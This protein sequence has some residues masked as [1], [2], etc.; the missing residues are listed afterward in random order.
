MAL[1]KIPIH[2][3]EVFRWDSGELNS[4]L[5]AEKGRTIAIDPA[6]DLTPDILCS[7]GLPAID[8]I[9]ITHVQQEHA[10]GCVNFPGVPVC[11]PEGDEYL[12]NGREAYLNC[13]TKWEAPWDWDGRGN[14]KGHLAGAPNEYPPENP[15]KLA[16]TLKDGDIFPPLRIVSTP[17][18]GK[19]AVSFLL[20]TKEGLC[21]FCGDLI[22]GG[23][24][25]IHSWYECEWDYGQNGG[26]KA[27]KN[28]VTRLMEMDVK[29]LMPSHGEIIFNGRKALKSLSEKLSRIL[30]SMGGEGPFNMNFPDSP[31]PGFREISQHLHQWKNGNLAVV[32]SASGEA[33]F[34]DDG[35][36][37][38]IPLP[39]R[40][41]SHRATIESLKKALG[42]K[43]ITL[44]IPTHYHGDHIDNIPDLVDDEGCKVIALDV[45]AGPMENPE[46]Y[47]LTCLLPWYGTLHD[48]VKVD[49]CVKSGTH[50]KWNEYDIE[51][52][53]LGGQ[54]YYHA[55]ITIKIDGEKV[56]FTG[57][58]CF[59]NCEGCETFI[60]YNDAEPFSKGYAYAVERLIE[61]TPTLLVS[62]HG[63]ALKNPMDHLFRKRAAWN[64]FKEIFTSLGAKLSPPGLRRS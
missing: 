62:G 13:L 32:L 26:Q 31:A 34:I 54:T 64:E 1:H 49:T 12:C 21:A 22:C 4:F 45:V 55:G 5:I 14:Y 17:G 63:M 61:R 53:H 35:L 6:V 10:S 33:L 18:H 28:S 51:I 3:F 8:L 25:Q 16:G 48:K 29:V 15:I 58:S 39:E 24:G 52:F 60:C 23:D 19:N 9:M 20:E 2:G 43:K 50:I 46:R 36:C 57:D 30:A 41:A 40:A 7:A 38:W 47:G 44:V 37:N 42:I 59:P 11:A 56:I 27:L